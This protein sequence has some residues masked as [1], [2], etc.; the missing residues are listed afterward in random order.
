M[1]LQGGV[2]VVGHSTPILVNVT[3]IGPELS[4]LPGKLSN[5][6]PIVEVR[7]VLS[8]PLVIIPVVIVLILGLE[9]S[10]EPPPSR[11]VSYPAMQSYF[12][13]LFDSHLYR[14]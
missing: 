2:D 6:E 4:L 7:I 13:S 11:I 12:F 3:I 1:P 10:G 5:V 9:V 14:K 8:I